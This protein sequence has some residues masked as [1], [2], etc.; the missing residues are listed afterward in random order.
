MQPN[1]QPPHGLQRRARGGRPLLTAL[2]VAGTL[3]PPAYLL[4]SANGGHASAQAYRVHNRAAAVPSRGTNSRA[5][6]IN[7]RAITPAGRQS[8]LGN[9]PLN[10]ILSPDGRRL[11]V[12]NG[13]AGVQSLQVVNASTGGVVQ[14]LTYYAPA[15]VFVGLTYSPDGTHAYASGGGQN[16][17]HLYDV[18]PAT[19]RLTP[20]GDIPLAGPASR[21]PSGLGSGPWPIGLSVGADGTTLYVAD[22][23]ANAVSVIDT[24]K[25]A[26]VPPS[27]GVPA[28]SATAAPTSAST[29]TPTSAPA[30]GTPTSAPTT[31]TPTS[32][33]ATGTPTSAPTTGTPTSAPT[34]GTPTSAPTTGTPTSAPAT[35]TPTSAPATGTPTSATATG[36]PTSAPTVADTATVAATTTAT[37]TATVAATTTATATATVAATTTATATATPSVTPTDAPSR[38]T[39]AP[40]PP[41]AAGITTVPVGSFPYATLLSPDGRRLYV[42]NW[43]DGT[44]SAIDTASD[45]VVATITV[46]LAN[47]TGPATSHP[48]ALALSP[49]GRFLFVSLSNS[50]A[51]AVVATATN[52][53]VRTF[54]D[55]PSN[56]APLS[57]SPQGLTVSP[58]GRVLYVANAGADDVTEFAIDAHGN[59]RRL[60]RIPTAWYP[61]AV[62][63]G[64]DG[65]T[66]YVTNGKGR[67]AGPNDNY[68]SPNPTRQAP[69]IIDAVTGY[70]DGY[71]NCNVDQYTGSM[72]VGTLSRI[73]TTTSASL[74]ARDT[75]R[76]EVDNGENNTAVDNRP[77]G[78]PIPAA[79]SGGAASPITHVIYI[80]K[81]NRTYDQ[82]FGDASVGEG[83][84][85]LTL[86]PRAVTPNLH[87]LADRFGLLDNF[88][89]DAEVSADGHNWITSANASDYNEK[90]WPQDYSPGAGRNRGYD[91]EGATTIN[92]SPGGYLWDAAH[93][94]GISYRDYGEFQVNGRS[95]LT[96]T[97]GAPCAGPVATSY[98]GRTIP[99]GSALCF[100][101]TTIVTSTTPNLA[102]HI[103]PRFRG[104]DS[105][106][107]DLDRVAE[108]Q[109][110]FNGFTASNTLPQFEILRLPNDHTAG[111]R[112]GAFTP[113]AFVAQNDDAVGRVVDIVS[114]SKYWASTA[115]FVTEDDAQNGPDHIDA[116]RTESLVI[117]PYTSRSELY[118]DHTLYDTAAMMRTMELIL[119]L[120][121]LSQYDANAQP[122]VNLFGATRDT[123]PYD[124]IAPTTST[125]AVNTPRSFEAGVSAQLNFSREDLAPEGVLNRILW[126]A[127][128]GAGTP[129]PVIHTGRVASAGPL[130]LEGAL[131]VLQAQALNGQLRRSHTTRVRLVR[132]NGGYLW[133]VSVQGGGH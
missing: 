88:Y 130:A 113:Q 5:V 59:A 108:W 56:G 79:G 133:G 1:D 55:R 39:T 87:A 9:L 85:S 4:T 45:T 131:G 127:V 86:F 44:L 126:G 91:F 38:T 80:V 23:L 98:L 71:C 95:P 109:R 125:T 76:V 61:T 2:L 114:H 15:S 25:V 116:H 64:G 129:Y 13:G 52:K 20:T 117:S 90:M 78:N 14:T 36:T 28:S 99:S 10:A 30:T 60:G 21:Y 32:A 122:I 49:D 69:P 101:P 51:I 26:T 115:I 29:G 73:A 84:A 34:T 50:D 47:T 121:P 93:E 11:L 43:G 128:K 68:L 41:S 31:G 119:G 57:S 110:E 102:G 104:Y 58:D 74:L 124:E 112:V 46:G 92:L 89:A 19:G 82:V 72:I 67:G 83:D 24:T 53:R 81:E 70:N 111:T 107:S 77:E 22:N 35:G 97:A 7:G 66:L 118:V 16:V 40:Q 12:A 6:L 106:Y 65:K 33:P 18:T 103:D 62:V 3:I 27:N 96:V 94:A 8:S 42:S 48:S 105:S 120:R 63:L 75:A 123:T 132:A 54:S 100:Q 37:A 17:I